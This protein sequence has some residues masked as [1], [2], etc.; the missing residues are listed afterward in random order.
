MYSVYPVV[1]VIMTQL[2]SSLLFSVL[3]LNLA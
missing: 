3:W 2:T 1:L